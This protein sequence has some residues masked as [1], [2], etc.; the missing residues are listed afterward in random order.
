MNKKAL[1]DGIELNPMAAAMGVVG[2]LIALVV[3]SQVEVGLIIK[4]LSA[5][6]SGIACYFVANHMF[7]K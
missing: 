1:F 7:N 6:F 3:I 2:A 5:L 4:F